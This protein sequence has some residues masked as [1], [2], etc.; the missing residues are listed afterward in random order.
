M[1][2]IRMGERYM[3][4]FQSEFNFFRFK[5]TLIFMENIMNIDQTRFKITLIALFFFV[6]GGVAMGQE[7]STQNFMKNISVMEA[8]KLIESN[9]DNQRFEL[10]DLRTLFEYQNIG[11]IKNGKLIDYYSVDFPEM[12][13]AMDRDKTYLIYCHSGGRSG[14]TM[15]VMENL[16]F[17][18]VYHLKSGI[19]GWKKEG[20]PVVQNQQ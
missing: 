17:Q 5:N 8:V 13:R 16:G 15:Q 3:K 12:L 1:K 11:H 7:S 20:L 10:V 14:K 18:K 6:V 19:K 9:L 2:L 4:N